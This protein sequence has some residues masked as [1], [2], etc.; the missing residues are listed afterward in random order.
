MSPQGVASPWLCRCFGLK[1]PVAQLPNHDITG[2]M[3]VEV[4]GVGEA[5]GKI[6]KRN[7]GHGTRE[8]WK[9]KERAI[10]KVDEGSIDCPNEWSENER[11]GRD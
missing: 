5:T 10:G 7:P 6:E 3:K 2:P 1:L 11:S 8:N 9:W 4:G